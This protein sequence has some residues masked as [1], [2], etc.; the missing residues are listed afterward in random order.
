MAEGSISV[1]KRAQ[2]AQRRAEAVQMRCDGNSLEVIALALEYENIEDA[3]RDINRALEI[4][5]AAQDHAVDIYRAMEL[6]RLDQMTLA[7]NPGLLRGVPRSVEIAL[8]VSERRA[9]LLGL[10]AGTKLEITTIDALDSQIAQLT[11]QL[12]AQ[13][14]ATGVDGALGV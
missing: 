3:S 12:E 7:L 5:I 14:I 6:R 10:D 9:K 11:A 8:K 13:G 1:A 4:N 2:T